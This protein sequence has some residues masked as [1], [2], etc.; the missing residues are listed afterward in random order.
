MEV[1]MDVITR[2]KVE[3]TSD[4]KDNFRR[5]FKGGKILLTASV[6]ELP[7]VVKSAALHKVAT[8]TEFTE[9]NGE[10]VRRPDTLGWVGSCR[11]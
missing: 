7:D 11:A 3:R 6:A 4:L 1:A 8:F 9:A 5:S 2:D 10:R